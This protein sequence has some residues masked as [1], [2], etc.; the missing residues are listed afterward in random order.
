MS[1]TNRGSIRRKDDDYQTPLWAIELIVQRFNMTGKVIL[2]PAVGSGNIVQV[3][4]KYYPKNYGIYGVDINQEYITNAVENLK[5]LAECGD[6]ITQPKYADTIWPDP[7]I[8]ITNPPYSLAL[9]FITKSLEIVKPGGLVI[10]LLRLSFLE[11][12]KRKE[13]HQY[14]PVDSI[15]V[16]S[17]R[18]SFTGDG[19]DACSY[20]WFVWRRG[21][22]EAK[23]IFV[24]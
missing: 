16:L 18:P 21:N 12:K 7:D 22:K 20:A 19:T 2:E 10:M 11:S 15:Y 13:F 8:I 4:K 6:Y 1:A 3:I 9:D 23:N 14:N 24:V 5:I 17:E